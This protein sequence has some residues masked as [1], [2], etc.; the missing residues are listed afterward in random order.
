MESI[1]VESTWVESIWV[2]RP[3]ERQGYGVGVDGAVQRCGATR[4]LLVRRISIG[5]TRCSCG[6]ACRERELG[7]RR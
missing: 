5:V 1:W 3:C 6:G 7:S 4:A 2:W